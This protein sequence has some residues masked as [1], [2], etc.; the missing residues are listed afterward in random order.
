MSKKINAI[1]VILIIVMLLSS[2]FVNR[3]QFTLY[4]KYPFQNDSKRIKL[5]GGYYYIRKEKSHKFEYSLIFYKDGKVKYNLTGLNHWGHYKITGDSL[6]IEYFY[7]DPMNFYKYNTM[8]LFGEIINDTTI[9]ITKDR[10][11]WCENV[12]AG[13]DNTTEKIFSPPRKFIFEKESKPDLTKAWFHDKNWYQEGLKQR[14]DK[15]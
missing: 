3:Q 10:C 7:V 8:E 9:H 4:E 6:H 5:N 14:E 2:C 1:L 12:Y 11:D 15:R 13:Y